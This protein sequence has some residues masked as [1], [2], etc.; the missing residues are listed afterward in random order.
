[1]L[2]FVPQP[3]L[4]EVN[5]YRVLISRGETRQIDSASFRSTTR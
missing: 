2:G 1:M 4:Q 5:I 3:N